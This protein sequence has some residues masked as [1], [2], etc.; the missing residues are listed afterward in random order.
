MPSAMRS[1]A[2]ATLATLL[3]FGVV[4]RADVLFDTL[5]DT[6]DG[7]V[8]LSAA[9]TRWYSQAFSTTATG[10]TISEVKL[11]LQAAAASDMEIFIY[12]NLSGAPDQAIGEAIYAANQ[13]VTSPLVI[14]GLAFDLDPSTQYWMVVRRYDGDTALWG[15]TDDVSFDNAYTSSSSGYATWTGSST[16]PLR[17]QI[18]AV[19]EPPAIVLSGVGLASAIYAMRRRRG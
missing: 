7:L 4:A 6:Q 14:S 17:M 11:D 1:L 15:Y 10:T 2:A 8:T 16:A 13:A 12:S 5:D 18:N 19:P 9:N 3:A